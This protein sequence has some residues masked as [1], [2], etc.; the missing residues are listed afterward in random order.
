[1]P[2]CFQELFSAACL[3]RTTYNKADNNYSILA[4][5]VIVKVIFPLC[6]SF[7]FLPPLSRWLPLSVGF[8]RRPSVMQTISSFPSDLPSACPFPTQCLF[9]CP[10]HFQ[11]SGIFPA[12]SNISA[13]L[14]SSPPSNRRTCP[15]SSTRFTVPDI[16]T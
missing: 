7:R 12:S 2:T 11:T 1:M 15:T 6:A 5:A 9:P 8:L 14:T 13:I 3:S 10:L 16:V 4:V